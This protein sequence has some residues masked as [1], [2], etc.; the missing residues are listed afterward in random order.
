[1][2]LDITQISSQIIEMAGRIKAGNRERSEHLRAAMTKLND[3]GLNLE[4]LKRKIA[5]SRTPNW[6]PAGLV[7]GFSQRYDAITTP[8]D[9]SA[10]A[11]DGSDIAVDRHKSARC[12]LINIGSVYLHYGGHPSAEL[13]STPKLY[14]EDADLVIKN[15][16]NK[17]REQQI[18]GALME[19]RR[20]VEECRKLADLAST[21]PPDE[22]LLAMMDGSLV[23]FGMQ[24]FPDFVV[25]EIV[26]KGFLSAL[27]TLRKLSLSRRLCLASY[28]SFPRSDDVVNALK[29]AICPQEAVDCD[30]T[31]QAGESA[32]DIL[33]GVND[34]MLYGEWLNTGQR[35][36]LFVN[37]SSILK[38]YGQHQVYFFYL[39]V[40][41]EIARVEIPEWIATRPDLLE[42]THSLVLDQCQRG[43]GYPVVLSESHEQAV[44]TGADRELFW[45]L[46]EEALVEQ[47]LPD[48]ISTKSRSKRT[49]WV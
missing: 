30:R 11:T 24:N 22:T 32:C 17:H 37:P 41:D 23:L 12:Y 40:E 45:G 49:R 26:D 34:R 43:Q 6:S 39:R 38:R 33:S 44:V 31:C 25:E 46:V 42:L 10:L 8:R 28:I 19:A 47:K 16:S 3:P 14:S 29:V 27:D 13:L 1:M 15:Q 36:A 48:Q 20:A 18:E 2:T 5:A 4:M 21:L 9:Y 7:E 35:S